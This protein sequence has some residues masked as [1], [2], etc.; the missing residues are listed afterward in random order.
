VDAFRSFDT[1]LLAKVGELNSRPRGYNIPICREGEYALPYGLG[2]LTL[3]RVSAD[4]RNCAKFE[5]GLDSV[6]EIAFLDE[7]LLVPG[8]HCLELRNWEPGDRIGTFEH[9]QPRKI[10][11][12]FQQH[13]IVLWERRHWP[14]LISD[15]HLVWARRFGAAPTFSAK[16]DQAGRIELIFWPGGV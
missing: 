13:K 11:E 14:V 15:Y 2:A 9:Q 7:H 10:K 1:L 12:L 3:R 5:T 8:H 4:M 16:P 6:G